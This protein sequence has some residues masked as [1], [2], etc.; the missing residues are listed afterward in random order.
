MQGHGHNIALRSDHS[1]V[2][3]GVN[4]YGQVSET[5]LG[6]DFVAVPSRHAHNL[7]LTLVPPTLS[8]LALG[9]LAVI[10]HRR[11]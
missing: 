1:L 3:W 5:P 9:G 6:D 10:R 8:F 4:D 7:A 2:A 11:K